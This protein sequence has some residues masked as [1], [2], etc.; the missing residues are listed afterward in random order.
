MY[1]NVYFCFLIIAFSCSS[2][3]CRFENNQSNI[4]KQPYF[5]GLKYDSVVSSYNLFNRSLTLMKLTQ[6]VNY[7]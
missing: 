6:V 4:S 7:K 3:E 1:S 5:L 2:V